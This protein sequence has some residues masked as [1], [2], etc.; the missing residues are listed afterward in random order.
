MSVP[1]LRFTNVIGYFWKKCKNN[2]R[3]SENK[4]QIKLKKSHSVHGSSV[5]TVIFNF[6]FW[7]MFIGLSVM[8]SSEI[9]LRLW[10]HEYLF[11]S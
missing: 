6:M 11:T 4:V 7:E 8:K 10:K 3:I 1:L 5:R 2:Y 9:L